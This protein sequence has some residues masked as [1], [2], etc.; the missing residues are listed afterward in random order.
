MERRKTEEQIYLEQ[1]E[2]EEDQGAIKEEPQ[3]S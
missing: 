3:V 2:E 1:D